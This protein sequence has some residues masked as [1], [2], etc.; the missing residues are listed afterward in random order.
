M[1]IAGAVWLILAQTVGFASGGFIAGRLRVQ[2]ESAP[3]DETHFRD[4]ATGFMAWTIGAAFTGLVLAGTTTLTG[5]VAARAGASMAA[6]AIQATGA[7]AS[8]P[9]G[10]FVDTLM[11]SNQPAAPAANANDQRAE[12][13]RI[14]ANTVS[15]GQLSGDDRTYLAGIVSARTGMSQDDAQKRVDEVT[16]SARERAKQVADTARKTAAYFSFWSFMALLFGA[17]AATLGGILGGDLRDE[18]ALGEPPSVAAG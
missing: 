2:A 10:Y 6:S 16:N 1:T 8:D 17:V 14:L 18:T 9:T 15:T 12:V 4:G 5:I 13:A 11:R 3:L 7:Q